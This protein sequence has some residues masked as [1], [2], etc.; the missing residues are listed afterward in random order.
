MVYLCC[1]ALLGALD[2]CPAGA[3]VRLG[4][5]RGYMAQ[6]LRVQ[7]TRGASGGNAF[8]AALRLQR[9]TYPPGIK[10]I[11]YLFILIY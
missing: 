6:L 2:A 3:I 10:I 7:R 9:P 1:S 8:A 4:V 5:E 11:L